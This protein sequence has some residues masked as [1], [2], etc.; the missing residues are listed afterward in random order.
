MTLRSIDISQ[1]EENL[2]VILLQEVI[3][4]H[5]AIVDLGGEVSDDETVFVRVAKNLLF[6]LEPD[7]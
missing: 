3:A 4:E 1:A 7:R 6:V 5:E 2:M